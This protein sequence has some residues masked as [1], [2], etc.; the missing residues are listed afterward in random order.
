MRVNSALAVLS[1]VMS[2]KSQVPVPAQSTLQPSK[3]LPVAG[4]GVAVR[5]TLL[6]LAKMPTAPVQLG[7]QLIL[8]G[9]LVTVPLPVP[10]LVRVTLAV[11][12]LKLTAWS[13][14]SPSP[15]PPE[16][17]SAP[18]LLAWKRKRAIV[19][20][21]PVLPIGGVKVTLWVPDAIP[22]LAI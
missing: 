16:G 14:T 18:V 8:T 20:P 13:S 10:D 3:V 5:L 7:P 9:V 17:P 19:V 21:L 2:L 4:T 11:S 1:A 12:E 15:A 22:A 6:C